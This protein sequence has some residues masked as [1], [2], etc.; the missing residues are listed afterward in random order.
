MRLSD[1]LR[2]KRGDVIAFV[3]AGGKSSAI[4]RLVNELAPQV[5]VVVT[6]TTKIALDQ[7]DLATE[8]L[9]LDSMSDLQ[10]AIGSLLQFESLLLTGQKDNVE[11]KWLGLKPDLVRIL[12]QTVHARDWV[13]LIEA[14]GARGKSL[15]VPA[16]HEPALPSGCS[17]VVPVV[18]LDAIGENVSSPKI[19]RPEILMRLLDLE[20][21]DRIN[22]KHV[23]DLLTSSQGGLKN[24]PAS[25]IVRILLN[26][27]DTAKDLDNGG[28][29]AQA[30]I[31]DQRIHSVLL[32]SVMEDVPVRESICRVGG[33]VL[34]AG[35]SS[36]LGGV[37]QLMTFRGKPLV[38]YS[39][40]TA[41]VGELD[42]IIVVVGKDGEAIT[43]SLKDYHI[44]IVENTE[45][46]LGQS[47]SV[48]VGL[49][50][51]HDHVDA[52]IF[53]LAD[54]PLVTS[55]LVV[56]LVKKHRQT[57]GPVIAPFVE[58]KRGNPVLFDRMTFDAL[59]E[60]K[61]DQGGR[62]IFSHYPVVQV[63]WDDSVLFDIDSEEDLQKMREIE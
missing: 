19:H 52:V 28:Q 30:L 11:P 58:G 27:A 2:I 36:R 34:A 4:R 22:N 44:Q 9:I 33:V 1:S 6:T 8:H 26:K 14:D 16:Q 45:P 51:I 41:L 37:K 24:I 57:L 17:L 12:I 50:A 54:M 29:I 59:R 61:G 40:E 31:K 23:V 13:L 25:A 5:P 62:A 38:A 56:A 21:S 43:N 39:A 18:G 3:G 53:L 49:N 46:E 60:V 47:S 20:E 15:K 10:S 63:E 7:V 32:A 42:P 35:E 48:Y 55:D